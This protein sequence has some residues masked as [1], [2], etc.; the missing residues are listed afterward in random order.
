MLSNAN[1]INSWFSWHEDN[2]KVSVKL[3]RDF[4]IKLADVVI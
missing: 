2:A 4:I 1:R 3:K